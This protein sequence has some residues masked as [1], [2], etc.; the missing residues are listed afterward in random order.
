M[1]RPS[2]MRS[3]FSLPLISIAAPCLVASFGIT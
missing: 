2:R 3:S 1:A